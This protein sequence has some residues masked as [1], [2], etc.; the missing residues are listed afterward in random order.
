M[1]LVWQASYRDSLAVWLQIS[2]SE[3]GREAAEVWRSTGES[4]LLRE[5]QVPKKT[6]QSWKMG[7]EREANLYGSGSIDLMKVSREVVGDWRS[8]G[9]SRLFRVPG[10]AP[11]CF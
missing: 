8:P 5:A 1:V 2:R 9:D 3:V 7:G 11:E 10:G 4:R 6:R